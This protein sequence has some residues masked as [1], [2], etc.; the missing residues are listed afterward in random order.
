MRGMKIFS[1]GG[2]QITGPEAFRKHFDAQDFLGSP[3]LA[4]GFAVQ[5]LGHLSAWDKY[6]SELLYQAVFI[7]EA[8]LGGLGLVGAEDYFGLAARELLSD[9][10]CEVVSALG[11]EAWARELLDESWTLAEAASALGGFDRERFFLTLAAGCF[12]AR[13][14]PK[15]QGLTPAAAAAA[16]LKRPVERD[17]GRWLE[18][19]EGSMELAPRREPYRIL[20]DRR[21]MAR[22]P[23]GESLTLC[24]LA[25]APDGEVELELHR[26]KYDDRPAMERIAPG[27]YRYITLAG[28][29]PVH[30][31]PLTAE[32]GYCTMQ[33]RG[34][35]L[36]RRMFNGRWE[37]VRLSGDVVSFAPEE[38]GRGYVAVLPDGELDLG[39][40]SLRGLPAVA[41][42]LSSGPAVEAGIR[43]GACL[44]LQSSGELVSN[45]ADAHASG[46]TSL[47]GFHF[48]TGGSR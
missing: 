37:S 44:V 47:E 18:L 33:R 11:R 15:T 21:R 38:D 1:M 6:N 7:P 10:E 43:G 48:R 8:C 16:Y 17:A 24:R 30:L 46:L 42:R 13:S 31:H 36:L 9:A 34:G 29:R 40:Y 5:Q 27:D 39:R 41:R 2:A 23:E 26:G 35:E 19:R 12:L 32:N 3:E 28:G 45:L 22:L 25:A 14:S 4:A 20:L